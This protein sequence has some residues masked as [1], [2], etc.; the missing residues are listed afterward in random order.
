[1][2][3]FLLSI[4]ALL[5]GPLIFSRGRQR[6][7]VR[8]FLDGFIL[9]TVAGIVCVFIIPD[10]I[11]VGGRLAILFLLLGLA[12]PVAIERV[13]H[14]LHHQAHI[15]VVIL[16]ATGLVIHALIDG[17][18]LLPAAGAALAHSAINT[19]WLQSMPE[20][21][22]A[23]SVILHRVP[24]GM[25]I[26]WSVRPSFGTPAAIATFAML[27]GATGAAYFLGAAAIELVEMQLLGYFQAFVAGS[28][29]HVVAF[30]VDH[31]RAESP[32]AG[33]RFA[34]WGFRTGVLF[35]MFMLFVLPYVH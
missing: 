26:W 33:R 12:F 10:A 30:G 23:M 16:A 9:V 3:T 2:T 18:A 35:G 28:L 34:G 32:D 14:R 5:L 7:G 20:S 19:G 1:M 31:E 11:A 24:V 8:Q 17:I 13:F 22:L 27:I 15:F 4:A 25:A 21:Q 29:A 6:P